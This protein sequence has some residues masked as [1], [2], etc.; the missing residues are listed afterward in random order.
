MDLFG[1][2]PKNPHVKRRNKSE[3]LLISNVLCYNESVLSIV[4]RD[5]I[6][7][8]GSLNLSRLENLIKRVCL[9]LREQVRSWTDVDE[10]NSLGES[11][12]K[13]FVNLS[14]KSKEL[15]L[16]LPHHRSLEVCLW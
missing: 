15:C 16:S 12:P 6:A 1:F 11:I 8:I 2:L 3:N 4:D 5:V 13:P 10:L 14:L 7:V 9:V